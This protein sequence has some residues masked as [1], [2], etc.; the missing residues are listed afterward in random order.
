MTGIKNNE[1]RMSKSKTRCFF[2]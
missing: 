2:I 1:L